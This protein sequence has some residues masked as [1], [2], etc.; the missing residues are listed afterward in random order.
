MAKSSRSSSPDDLLHR[1]DDF[2]RHDPTKAVAT[3]FGVG[4][5][6]QLLP[7]RALASTLVFLGLLLLR[8]VLFFLG[9]LKAFDLARARSF[10]AKKLS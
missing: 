8:P 6:L 9:V 10:P 1:S 2:I 3:A 5:L 7:L 4:F